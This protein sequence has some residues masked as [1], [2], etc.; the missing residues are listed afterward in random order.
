MA[1]RDRLLAQADALVRELEGRRAKPAPGIAAP[2]AAPER[3]TTLARPLVKPSAGEADQPPLSHRRPRSDAQN[4]SAIAIPMAADT[5]RDDIAMRVAKFREHQTR[6]GVERQAFYEM[7]RRELLNTI[8][9]QPIDRS[10]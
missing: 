4:A 6:L 9:V 8:G 5:L 3:H 10:D 1:E 2:P 7:K